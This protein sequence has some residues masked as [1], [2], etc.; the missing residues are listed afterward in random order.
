MQNVV[1]S[2]SMLPCSSSTFF[3]FIGQLCLSWTCEK[4]IKHLVCLLAKNI[5]WLDGGLL[6][7]KVKFQVSIFRVNFWC[8]C[9]CVI[10]FKIYFVACSF[11]TEMSF[12]FLITYGVECCLWRIAHSFCFW[13]SLISTYS[14]KKKGR[15]NTILGWLCTVPKLSLPVAF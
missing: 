2:E 6:V 9:S 10:N 3:S 1:V 4:R 12:T 7:I 11:T 15:M 5:L 13:F 8:S 14:D